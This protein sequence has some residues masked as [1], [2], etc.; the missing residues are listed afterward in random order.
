M[1]LCLLAILQTGIVAGPML[2]WNQS[3]GLH[4]SMSWSTKVLF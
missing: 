1:I 3:G 2:Y 4:A